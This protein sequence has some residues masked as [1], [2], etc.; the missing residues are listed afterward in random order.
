MRIRTLTVKGAT[1]RHGR[2]VLAVVAALLAFFAA[3]TAL[4]LVVHVGATRM[5]HHKGALTVEA[6]LKATND[7][8]T[9][10]AQLLAGTALTGGLV[11]TARTFLLTRQAQ[12][13]ERYKSAVE[14]IGNN[15]AT[16]RAGGVYSLGQLSA[17]SSPYRQMLEDV[18][19]ALVR[20]RAIASPLGP[21]VQAAM[22]VLG[23]RPVRQ[24]A[25]R[26]P[27][28][29]LRGVNLIGADLVGANLER[30]LLDGACLWGAKLTDAKLRNASLVNALLSEAD[31]SSAH[32][33]NCVMTGA[34]VRGTCFYHADMRGADV[35]G[36]D[37][38]E[39]VDLTETQRAEMQGGRPQSP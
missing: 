8:R 35:T 37:L 7:A 28:V 17:E 27:R 3:F 12:H 19:S 29:D 14:Q 32:M 22:T 24:L 2:A 15:N 13:S 23:R 16:V 18:L 20:E 39:A 21:D 25:D 30:V 1:A 5:V 6:R 26:S 31:L 36:C 33:R 34:I 10:L 9:S 4:A 38:S 11:F